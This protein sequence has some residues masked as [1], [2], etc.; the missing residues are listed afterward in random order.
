MRPDAAFHAAVL[1][2]VSYLSQVSMSEWQSV[3]DGATQQA[4]LS[5]CTA[6][7]RKSCLQ[8]GLQP[9][10][11]QYLLATQSAMPHPAACLPLCSN[12]EG[13]ISARLPATQFCS[14]LKQLLFPAV[15]FA[16]P[17]P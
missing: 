9:K 14:E 1:Q 10:T 4:G 2:S 16:L 6:T 12:V 7:H 13:L 15:P 5:S 3:L 11:L 8:D 17:V